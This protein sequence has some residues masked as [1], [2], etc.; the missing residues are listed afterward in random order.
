MS[1]CM[2]Q[3]RQGTAHPSTH[4]RGY[5]CQMSTNLLKWKVFSSA[6]TPHPPLV[7]G[8]HNR[9]GRTPPNCLPTLTAFSDYHHPNRRRRCRNTRNVFVHR[10]HGKPNIKNT[11]TFV[12]KKHR[13]RSVHPCQ[14]GVSK[15]YTVLCTFFFTLFFLLYTWFSLKYVRKITHTTTYSTAGKGHRMVE[16]FAYWKRS[17][18]FCAK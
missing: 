3:C 6:L 2:Q 1:K 8:M 7:T 10:Y 12:R 18:D 17:F 14:D 5:A 4:R 16:V 13:Y 11:R 15:F 9:R